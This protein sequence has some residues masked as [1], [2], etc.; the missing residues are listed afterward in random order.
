MVQVNEG[1]G[2]E[3]KREDKSSNL[4]QRCIVTVTE[5]AM[6]NNRSTID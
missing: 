4:L 6:V 5:N 3:V 1:G 2:D